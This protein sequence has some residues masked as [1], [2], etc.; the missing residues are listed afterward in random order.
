MAERGINITNLGAKVAL[1]GQRQEYI[2]VYEVDIPRGLDFPLIQEWIPDGGG[3]FGFSALF[4]DGSNVKAAFIHKKLRMYPI[5]GGPSTLREG[6][7]HLLDNV[8]KGQWTAIS[9]DPGLEVEGT[10]AVPQVDGP[11]HALRH[12]PVCCGQDVLLPAHAGLPCHSVKRGFL[13]P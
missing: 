5:Q 2:Q 13:M 6:V 10:I 12:L 11:R 7:A 8:F 3:T 1:V 4:D 9:E